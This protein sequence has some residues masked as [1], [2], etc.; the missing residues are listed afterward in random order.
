VDSF[1]DGLLDVALLPELAG[2]AVDRYLG[3]RSLT[4]L[5]ALGQLP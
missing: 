2:Q 4:D 1:T 3:Y 5:N